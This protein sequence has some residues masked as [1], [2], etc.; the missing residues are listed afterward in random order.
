MR[1]HLPAPPWAAVLIAA[2]AAC[3][4]PGGSPGTGP[5]SEL[6]SSVGAVAR[7]ETDGA[8]NAFSL[9]TQLTPLG[10]GPG[11][12]C[13]APSSSTD[14]DGD[15][16]PDDAT[17]IFTAPPCRFTGYRG[18]TL[19]LVGQL[20]IQD[21]TP[22]AAGFGYDASLV[23]VRATFTPPGDTPD[24][25]SVTRN[26]T[27][28]LTGA[29]AGLQLAADLQ[30]I[31]TFT[32]LADANVDERWTV[33]FTPE[34]PLQINQPLPSGTLDLTGTLGWI[35]GAETIDLAVSTPV[36]IHYNAACTGDPRRFDAGELHA[37]GT[38]EGFA[39]YVRVRWV[40]CGQDPEIGFVAA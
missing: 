19:D 16:I 11:P 37:A 3:S 38:F 35:R 39:G 18:G 10:A 22:D 30:V 8:L 2:L 5:S 17:W 12:A 14:N 1:H 4:D 36:P 40:G 6:T 31:R 33:S 13:V 21:P 24:I 23:A 9:P 34:T 32:G 7:D 15:G 26:G 20:R 28:S 25:Y 27:R 29:V